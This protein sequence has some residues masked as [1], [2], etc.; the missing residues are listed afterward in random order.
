MQTMMAA[1]VRR[2]SENVTEHHGANAMADT[3]AAAYRATSQ[4]ASSRAMPMA[5]RMSASATLVMFSFRPDTSTASSTPVRPVARRR[6]KAGGAGGA[7]AGTAPGRG[8][9]DTGNS[10]DEDQSTQYR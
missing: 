10:V 7:A 9:A 6:P 2:R 4:L 3:E 1:A 8:T 5:P